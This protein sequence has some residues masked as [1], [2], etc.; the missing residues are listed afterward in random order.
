MTS[1]ILETLDVAAKRCGCGSEEV[2]RFA[3]HDRKAWWQ[4]EQGILA[5]LILRG[6]YDGKFATCTTPVWT[7]PVDISASNPAAWCWTRSGGMQATS[8]VATSVPTT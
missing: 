7:K 8:T 6:D 5:Y 2:H 3:F 4:Q 1:P